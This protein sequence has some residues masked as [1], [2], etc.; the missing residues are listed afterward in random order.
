MTDPTAVDDS[1]PQKAQI[2]PKLGIFDG[3]ESYR[4]PSEGDL[5]R[6]M[7]AGLVVA[8]ANVLLDLYRYTE[9]G[10]QLLLSVMAKLGNQLWIPNQVLVEFWRHRLETVSA[11]KAS[12]ASAIKELQD[13]KGKATGVLRNWA[14]RFALPEDELKRIFEDL[15]SGF[16]AATKAVDDLVVKHAGPAD[17]DTAADPVV[18]ALEKALAA[19]VGAPLSPERYK[20]VALEGQRR[21]TQK[22]PPG[23][24][25]AGKGDNAVG[26]FLVWSQILDEARLRKCDVLLVT[27][28]VKED[29]WRRDNRQASGPRQELIDEMSCEAGTRLYML[30]PRQFTALGASVFAI[31]A[32][33][34]GLDDIDR[35]DRSREEV[36]EEVAETLQ[37]LWNPSAVEALLEKLVSGG[38][39]DRAAVI[40]WAADNEGFVSHETI[41]ELCHYSPEAKLNGL[42]RPISRFTM[43]LQAA[44]LLPDHV[45]PLLQAVYDPNYSYVKAS[46][47]RLHASAE[48]LVQAL[49]EAEGDDPE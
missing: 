15:N 18:A 32:A 9:Q 27:G 17:R 38:Y 21:V 47:F 48:P 19:R 13:I 37:G 20:E 14:G 22:I 2:Q 34:T 1:M 8:D 12:A 29:W 23:Y 26:D 11:P 7:N 33:E 44:G 6:V 49:A 39:E 3:F 10:R 43:E 35:V 36:T 45:A 31:D 28:D 16:E 46:G 4:S 30:T 41:R 40:R 42:V 24:M 25:D 5:A